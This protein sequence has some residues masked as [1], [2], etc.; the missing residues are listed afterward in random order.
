MV[1]EPASEG[2]TGAAGR[3]GGDREARADERSGLA[4]EIPFAPV[5]PQSE[6]QGELPETSACTREASAQ[7][8]PA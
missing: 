7:P 3:E 6:Y 2:T 5:L 8:D 4:G 1:A